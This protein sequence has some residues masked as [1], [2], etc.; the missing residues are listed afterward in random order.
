MPELGVEY[1]PIVLWIDDDPQTFRY[2]SRHIERRGAEVFDF[3]DID[4]LRNRAFWRHLADIGRPSLIC[5][6]LRNTPAVEALQAFLNSVPVTGVISDLEIGRNPNAGLIVISAA[7]LSRYKPKTAIYSGRV[8]RS[9]QSL[10]TVLGTSEIIKKGGNSKPLVEELITNWLSLARLVRPRPSAALNHHLQ[11][12]EKENRRL[13]KEMT[14]LRQ[15]LQ[16]KDQNLAS[17]EKAKSQE[18]SVFRT[19]LSTLQEQLQLVVADHHD[20]INT[21]SLTVEALEQL[22]R[23]PKYL[24]PVVAE[25]LERARIS[26]KHCDVLVASLTTLSTQPER[27]EIPEPSSLTRALTEALQIVQRKVP[28]TV[29][30]NSSVA[31]QLPLSAVPEHLL[32]RCILNLL[33]NALEAVQEGGVIRLTVNKPTKNAKYLLLR[34]SDDGIGIKKADIS[35]VFE[36][37]FSTKGDQHGL[38]LFIVRKI[39]NDYGGSVKLQSIRR[40]GT[41]VTLRIPTA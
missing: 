29:N 24:P 23:E 27:R 2:V 39:M 17:R 8:D 28:D 26:A 33:L 20:L 38:G 31:N 7:T 6:T 5:V 16:Q 14:R 1:F 15:L 22:A 30:L 13:K 11:T 4:V 34:I 40:K 35:K 25:E 37:D 41:D 36:R 19:E 21:S 32:V 9:L 10:A 12:L 3:S 18:E